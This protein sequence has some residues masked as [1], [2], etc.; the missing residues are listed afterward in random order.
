[1]NCY[2]K[3]HINKFHTKYCSRNFVQDDVA[4]FTLLA[5]DYTPKG[6]IFKELGDFLAHPDKKDRGIVIDSYNEVIELFDLKT[7]AFFDSSSERIDVKASKGLG[8]L[9]LT[10]L[11]T[12]LFAKI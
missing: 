10:K 5:R 7:E 12:F 1:M 8:L 11:T 3:H 6:S 9:D 2:T 4:F